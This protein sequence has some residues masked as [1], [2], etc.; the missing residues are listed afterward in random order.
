M[1]HTRK[2]IVDLAGPGEL[3]A[4]ARQ[5]VADGDLAG[6]VLLV[7]AILEVNSDV[8]RVPNLEDEKPWIRN[9]LSLFDWPPNL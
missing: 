8:L 5:K 1:H 4:A 9:R 6:A 2:S 3:L 7:I